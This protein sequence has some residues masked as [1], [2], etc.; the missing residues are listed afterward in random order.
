MILFFSVPL[1]P[2]DLKQ[3]TDVPNVVAEPENK[4]TFM[5]TEEYITLIEKSMLAHGKMSVKFV[6]EGLNSVFVTFTMETRSPYFERVKDVV[7]RLVEAGICPH[8]LNGLYPTLART[9]EVVPALVLTWEDLAIGFFVCLIPLT[10][11][12]FAFICEVAPPKIKALAIKTRDL[13][14]FL[15]LMRAFTQIK[16]ISN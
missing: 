16:R 1:K 7:V 6:K 5:V 11:S 3:I 14:T 9:E 2:V 4:L 8:R 13:L 12:V 10:L 15:F